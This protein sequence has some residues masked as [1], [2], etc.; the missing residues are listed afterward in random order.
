MRTAVYH[1]WKARFFQPSLRKNE[2]NVVVKAST[3][4]A[5]QLR[6]AKRQANKTRADGLARQQ[7]HVPGAE[8]MAYTLDDCCIVGGH[9][10]QLIDKVHYYLYRYEPTLARQCV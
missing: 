3:Y 4:K 10:T 1:V 6:A 8:G 2:F 9:I 5:A 7:L